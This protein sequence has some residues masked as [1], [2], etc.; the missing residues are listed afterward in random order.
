[1]QISRF[2]SARGA[3]VFVPAL[4]AA[5]L[6]ACN[7]QIGTGIEARDAWTRSYPVKPGVVLEVHETVGLVQVDASDGDTIVVNATRIAKA[8][9]EEA[10]KAMLADY[11]IAETITP[12]QITLDGTSTDS[13]IGF[14]KSRHVEYHITVPR[15]TAVTIKSINSEIR[16]TG[17]AGALRV[18][19]SNGEITGTAL[20]NGAE[21]HS[22]NG[23][24]TLDLAKLGDAGV[25]CKMSNGQVSV[26][27]PA[28]TKATV[29]VNLVN[30]EIQTSK[31]DVAAHEQTGRR[32]RGTIGGG[33]P[34]VRIDMINGEVR[35]IGK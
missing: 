6:S 30:G 35:L 11:K 33:G 34:D 25:R 18:E 31:L 14:N 21:V 2:L 15:A 19:T 17:I 20:G 8:S 9:T 29:D 24:V 28:D 10:A 1:M 7:L 27:V 26:S 4:W 22:V 3:R 23:T 13:S 5:L 32:L 12:E 16:V